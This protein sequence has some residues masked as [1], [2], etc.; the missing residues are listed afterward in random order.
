MG[1]GFGDYLAASTFADRKPERL[2]ACVA[3]WDA[4][5]YAR[6]DPPCLRRVDSA[7]RYPRDLEGEPHADGE[8]WSACLWELRAAL[9][10]DVADRLVLAH[11][12]LV[13]PRATFRT[14]VA[15]LLTAD[16]RLSGGKN[17]AAIREVFERRGV[18]PRARSRRR[19]P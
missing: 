19:A 16:R 18:L 5:A 11:H 2:R 12:H 14:A 1:E 13:T 15:A 10:A 9:G 3:S 4:V 6:T 8:I 7:K 17:S